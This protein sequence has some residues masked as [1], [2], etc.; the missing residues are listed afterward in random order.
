MRGREVEK[1]RRPEMTSGGREEELGVRL[2]GLYFRSLAVGSSPP[3]PP[4][5]SCKGLHIYTHS[6]TGI[7]KYFPP[8]AS[9][10][11]HTINELEIVL[12]VSH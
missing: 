1:R 12:Y 10:C 2:D 4:P 6:S 5:H 7:E 3:P 8:T 9:G 11:S